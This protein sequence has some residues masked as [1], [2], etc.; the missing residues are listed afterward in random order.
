MV[1][2]DVSR[3]W[4]LNYRQPACSWE[5]EGDKKHE[6][7]ALFLPAFLIQDSHDTDLF[8]PKLLALSTKT[9]STY[10]TGVPMSRNNL[11]SIRPLFEVMHGSS[12]IDD[13]YPLL[14]LRVIPT[15]GNKVA[16]PQKPSRIYASTKNSDSRLKSAGHIW[17]QNRKELENFML[18]RFP[19]EVAVEKES[20]Q[21]LS[22]YSI[23]SSVA[24]IERPYINPR[25][26]RYMSSNRS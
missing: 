21:R 23:S 8:S 18:F 11:V 1:I 5:P 17:L 26:A 15:C 24:Y 22:N 14:S 12:R 2:N 6:H 25:I 3:S 19:P 7:V 20:A 13:E 9:F 10:G 16:T 4:A